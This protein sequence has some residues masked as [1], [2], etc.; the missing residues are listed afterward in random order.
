MSQEL[1]KKDEVI[2]SQAMCDSQAFR[3]ICGLEAGHEG[4]H[5]C[6]CGGSWLGSKEGGDFEAF[7]LPGDNPNF[8]WGS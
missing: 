2:E 4:P 1:I 8:V 6:R 3:C 7:S 5:V